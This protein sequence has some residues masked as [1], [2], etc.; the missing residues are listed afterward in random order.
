VSKTE[1]E[2]LLRVTGIITTAQKEKKAAL[3][4][5]LNASTFSR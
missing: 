1:L 2:D 4:K 5:V 3:L